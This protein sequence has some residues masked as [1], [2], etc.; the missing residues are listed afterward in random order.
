[1]GADGYPEQVRV[2][3]D[4]ELTVT[5]DLD[6]LPPVEHRVGLLMLAAGVD[7]RVIDPSRLVACSPALAAEL[8]VDHRRTL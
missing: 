5:L 4:D 8:L 7:A 6:L 2:V 3:D 1:M